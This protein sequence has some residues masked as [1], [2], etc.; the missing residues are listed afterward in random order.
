MFLNPGFQSTP[1]HYRAV[2][3]ADVGWTVLEPNN[4]NWKYGSAACNKRYECM[5]LAIPQ[6]ADRLPLVPELIEAGGCGLCIPHDSAED[7]AA[8]VNRLLGDT[9]LRRQMGERGRQLHLGQY[10]YD[11]QFQHVV[12][13]IRKATGAASNREMAARV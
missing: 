2:A 12:D 13:F 9:T 6:V 11:H 4:D 5:A 1:E 3:G 10:N 7:A 8:A